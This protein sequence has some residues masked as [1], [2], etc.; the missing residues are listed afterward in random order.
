LAVLWSLFILFF[1]VVCAATT[2]WVIGN[3]QPAYRIGAEETTWFVALKF[4]NSG[5]RS[6]P[7]LVSGVRQTWA[8]TAEFSF[9]GEVERHWDRFLLLAGSADGKMPLILNNDLADAYVVRLKIGLPPSLVLGAV[10]LLYLSGFWSMPEGELALDPAEIAARPDAMPSTQSVAVLLSYPDTFKPVMV[11]F[12]K[13][14]TLARYDEPSPG[15]P[16]PSGR[17]AYARYGLVAFQAIHR[18]GGLHSFFGRVEEVLHAA[19]S[20]LTAG[21]WDDI[22]VMQYSEPKGIL[23]MEQIPAYRAALTHRDAGLERTVII[24]ALQ[25]EASGH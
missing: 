4:K 9:I 14:R 19:K 17:R 13:Y 8:A 7:E 24:T 18:T 16:A 25:D 1:I 15:N 23:T 3:R 12:L 2:L 20:G 22:G 10:R 5:H 6:A 11:N 21:T